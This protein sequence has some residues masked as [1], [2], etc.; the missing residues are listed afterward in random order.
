M[1]RVGGT[2]RRALGGS[3][4]GPGGAASAF[5]QLCDQGQPL[6]LSGPQTHGAS[7]GGLSALPA[8]SLMLV[9]CFQRLLLGTKEAQLFLC[10][11]PPP[12]GGQHLGGTGREGARPGGQER[13]S[14]CLLG[15]WERVAR[16][17]GK[18]SRQSQDFPF[19]GG[20]LLPNKALRQNEG[21][22]GSP[23]GLLGTLVAFPR[24]PLSEEPAGGEPARRPP[25]AR[26]AWHEPLFT[27]S[28]QRLEMADAMGFAS[29]LPE[30][31]NYLSSNI[32]SVDSYPAASESREGVGP[33]GCQSGRPV[34]NL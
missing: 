13:G 11:P 24:P 34:I 27:I 16:L 22:Q 29:L 5:S 12:G 20:D 32:R 3:A 6:A 28:K 15:G 26:A 21:S 14:F 33:A 4:P 9:P 1:E 8:P 30:A 31:R 19:L 7:V 23:Q 17:P 25:T 10:Q 18:A 2:E